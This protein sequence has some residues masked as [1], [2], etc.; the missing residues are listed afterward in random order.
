M[1]YEYPKAWKKSLFAI[2]NDIL[3]VKNRRIYLTLMVTIFSMKRRL[4][5]AKHQIVSNL[6]VLQFSG[7]QTSEHS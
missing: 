4:T 1:P 6:S 3:Q 5:V 7:L 2:I